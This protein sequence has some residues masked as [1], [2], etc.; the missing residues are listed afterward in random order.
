MSAGLVRDLARAV[1]KVAL[2]APGGAFSV[3]TDPNEID[4]GRLQALVGAGMNRA[5]AGVQDFDPEIQM[6]IGRKQG[7][8]RTRDV[9]AM[10]RDHRITSL[11]ADIRVGLRH[12][13][14]RKI[15]VS[16]VRLRRFAP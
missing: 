9:E 13:T 4:A 8:E 11:N 3:E 6:G 7:F 10:I 16:V 15:A 1:F 2:M 5:S 14:P 12:Q